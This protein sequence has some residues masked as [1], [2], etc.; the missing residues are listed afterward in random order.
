MRVGA[1]WAVAVDWVRERMSADPGVRGAFFSGST[2][3]LAVWQAEGGRDW[4]H[5]D[6]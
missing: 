6:G 4:R 3:G 1:A 2:V 5:G